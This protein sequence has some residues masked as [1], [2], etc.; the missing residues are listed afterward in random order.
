[1]K[2]G[3]KSR[4][5]IIIYLA[6]MAVILLLMGISVPEPD[7]QTKLLPLMLGGL[8]LILAGTGLLREFRGKRKPVKEGEEACAPKPSEEAREGFRRLLLNLVWVLGFFLGIYLVGFLVAIP[9]FVITYMLWLKVKWWQTVIYAV[10]AEGVIYAAFG[11][12]FR[13]VF[14]RGLLIDLLFP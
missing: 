11:I 1:M 8:I 12:A 9:I 4:A 14:Y 3:Q 2:T 13:V 7:I 6:I 5:D 10:L